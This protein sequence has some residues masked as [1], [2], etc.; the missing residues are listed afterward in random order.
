[1]VANAATPQEAAKIYPASYWASL[2]RPP[3][4]GAASPKVCQPGTLACGFSSRLQPVSSNWNGKHGEF[5]GTEDLGDLYQPQPGDEE[6]R[7]PA[8]Q[9]IAAN[10]SC[11]LGEAHQGR[12][13]TSGPA[14]AHGDRTQL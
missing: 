2:I 1:P 4:Q 11:R 13:S 14:T 9:G 5:Y 12:G 3:G 7:R 8:W 6:E 10:D